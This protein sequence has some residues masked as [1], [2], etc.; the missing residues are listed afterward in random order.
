MQNHSLDRW[1]HRK[2]RASSLTSSVRDVVLDWP[3]RL[4][5]AIGAA[6]GLCYMHHDCSPAIIHRDVKSNNIL[7]DFEFKVTIADFSL[8]KILVKHGE[9]NIM[10]AFV[11]YFGYIAPGIHSKL[12]AFEVSNNKFTGQLLENL[13]VG[14]TL[15]VVVAFSNN[16]TGTIPKS[17]GSFNA[18]LTIQLYSNNFSDEVPSRLWRSLNLSN[19]MLSDNSFS[20]ELLS[21]VAWNFSWIEISNKKFS[22]QIPTWISS[23]ES[24]VVF[25]ASNNLFCGQIPLELTKLPQLITLLLDGNQLTGNFSLEITSWNSLIALNLARNKFYRRIP[26]VIGSLPDLLEL[27][28]SNNQFFGPIPPELGHL[29]LTYL[30][31][32]SIQLTGQVLDEFC[33]MAFENNFLNNSNLCAISSLSSIPSCYAKSH[34]STKVS[35]FS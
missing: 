7:L 2:K 23:W 24:L 21:K 31:L 1:I 32:F 33:N 29:R 9:P 28:L 3:I 4:Q 34:D 10:S 26:V 19:L 14:G 17:L 12:D 25:K 8:A 30:N 15:F 16:L 22:G 5:I 11:G 13:C 35:R 27:D 20:G 6:Q 18:L